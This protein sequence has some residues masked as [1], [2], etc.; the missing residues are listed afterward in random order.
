II[1]YCTDTGVCDALYE[2]S[3][4]ADLLISECSYKL[5]QEEWGW[6]HL[7]PEEIA[8]VA[9]KSNV[10]RLVLTHFD[11]SL[12]PTLESRKKAVDKVKLIFKATL[13]AYDTF[14]LKI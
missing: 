6:P 9:R 2:L 1:S 5:G 14:E 12:F 4:N 7:K 3:N 13:S 11:A 10:K 8:T